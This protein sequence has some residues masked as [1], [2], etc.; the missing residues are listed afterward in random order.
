MTSSRSSS[1]LWYKV[2]MTDLEFFFI[3]KPTSIEKKLK[4][5]R[6]YKISTKNEKG[7]THYKK[8]LQLSKIIPIE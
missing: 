4:N 8:G 5:I 7:D 3:K 6:A 2:S 1:D